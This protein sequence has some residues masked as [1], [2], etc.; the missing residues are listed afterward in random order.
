MRSAGKSIIWFL[1]AG[2]FNGLL[3]WLRM[4][5]REREMDAA[6]RLQGDASHGGRHPDAEVDV[7]TG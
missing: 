3:T 6:Q 1:V 4:Y 2:I 7:R 5:A